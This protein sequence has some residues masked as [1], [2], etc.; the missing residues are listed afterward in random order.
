MG[1]KKYVGYKWPNLSVCYDNP[2]TLRYPGS[3]K[4]SRYYFFINVNLNEVDTA[5]VTIMWT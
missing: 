1:S 2:L 3:W 4:S 5:F